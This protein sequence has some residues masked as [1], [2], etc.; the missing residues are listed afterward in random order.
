MYIYIYV[1]NIYIYMYIIYIYI[2]I[3]IYVPFSKQ[4]PKLDLVGFPM[5]SPSNLRC[6]RAPAPALGGSPLHRPKAS[7]L[8]SSPGPPSAADAPGLG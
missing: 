3:C 2:F 1:Y 7:L 8:G 5:I 4:P 6:A